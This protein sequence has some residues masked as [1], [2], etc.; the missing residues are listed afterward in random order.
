MY[1]THARTL[2][3]SISQPIVQPPSAFT[4]N[5]PPPPLQPPIT[6]DDP[7]VGADCKARPVPSVG[8]IDPQS[9]QFS[10]NSTYIKVPPPALHRPSD[11]DLFLVDGQRRLNHEY[12]KTHFVRE[13][14]LREQQAL[15]IIE[16]ATNVLSRERN[17]VSIT[18]PVTSES[19]FI[20]STQWLNHL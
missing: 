4:R 19:S 11:E 17:L 16:Q 20:S 1:N 2:S 14:R 6:I 9:I 13:G 10:L 8:R 15:Y 3:A 18:S 12:L 5:G 7:F